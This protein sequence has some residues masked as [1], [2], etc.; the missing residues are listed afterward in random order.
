M[1]CNVEL[2]NN[3]GYKW[4]YLNNIDREVW[5]KGL[6]V[7]DKQIFKGNDF[8]VLVASLTKEELLEKCGVADGHFAIVI[9]DNDGVRVVADHM[10]SFPIFIIKNKDYTVTDFINDS[11]ISKSE[12]DDVQVSAFEN[13][14]FTLEEKTLFKEIEQVSSGVICTIDDNGISYNDYWQFCYADNQIKQENEAV[15]FIANGYDELFALCKDIVGSKTVV[16]P[17][18]GGYDSR[19]VLNGLLKNGVDKNRIITFTYGRSGYEDGVLSKQIADAVGVKHYFVDYCTTEAK[20]FFKKQFPDF[21]AYAGMIASVPCIQEWYAVSELKRQGVI[22]ENCI[23]MPGYGGVLPGH[24]VRKFMFEDEP[25]IKEKISA[26]IKDTL[27]SN[28]SRRSDSEVAALQELFI[29]SKYFSNNVNY[30]EGY[31]R[32][33][34]AEEQAKFILNAARDY[35][36]VGCEWVTPFFFKMQYNV[37]GKIDNELRWCNKAFF[38]CMKTY[39][40]PVLNSI[41][42]TGSKVA[43]AS[44]TSFGLLKKVGSKLKIMFRRAQAHYLF[45]MIPAKEFYGVFFKNKLAVSINHLVACQYLK[46]LKKR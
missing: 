9:K 40:L 19:L 6:F 16:I 41:Q 14:L 20:R 12:F 28:H 43:K 7:F 24:Y 23:F 30:V 5:V 21:S 31:E 2:I 25:N 39:F 34:Y 44:N 17:L 15:N 22:D 18:S 29:D 8:A 13:A 10:R 38:A 27:L 4:F 33:V 46:S 3:S 37:W 36:M 42:F 26:H 32:L 35:E 11:V 1:I 45:G